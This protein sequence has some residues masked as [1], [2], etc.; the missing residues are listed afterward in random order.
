MQSAS[1]RRVGAASGGVFAVVL[2]IASGNGTEAFLA[3]RAIAG[4]AALALFVPF[5]AYLTSVLRAAEGPDGWLASTAYASG[6]AGITL[7][8]VSV[9]PALALHRAHVAD[10]T[11]LHKLFDGLDGGATV[12][13]LY[14]LAVFCAATAAVSIRTGALPRWLGW[15][16]AVT[17]VALAVNGAFLEASFVPALLLFVAW[18]LL[19]SIHLVRRTMRAATT[20]GELTTA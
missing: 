2:F 16:A 19:A 10:G 9:L 14:P 6:L 7:K 4:V 5:L 3:P 20:V 13:A 11:A 8:I 12:I 17:A 1:L 18:T 15:A